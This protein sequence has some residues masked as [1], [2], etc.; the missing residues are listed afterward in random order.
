MDN[1]DLGDLYILADSAFNSGSECNR[2]I[3]KMLKSSDIEPNKFSQL[4]G[5]RQGAEWDKRAFQGLFARLK[6]RLPHS[7]RQR[8]IIFED[9]ILLFNFRTE[10][11]GLNQVKTVYFDEE[12]DEFEGKLKAE[13]PG[14]SEWKFEELVKTNADEQMKNV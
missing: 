4:V 13:Y 5:A 11:I 7:A 9:C 2:K 10:K 1:I 6:T 14:N 3:Y 12:L 8:R